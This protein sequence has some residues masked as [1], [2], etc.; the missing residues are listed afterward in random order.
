MGFL[1]SPS[2]VSLINNLILITIESIQ[3]AFALLK[4]LSSSF[5]DPFHSSLELSMHLL[6]LLVL[7]PRYDLHSLLH[8]H[9]LSQERQFH[10]SKIESLQ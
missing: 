10:I 7:S 1:L 2:G 8:S 4:S 3:I 9:P 6:I 5:L